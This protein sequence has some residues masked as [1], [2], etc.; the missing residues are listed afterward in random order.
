MKAHYL[1]QLICLVGG[2]DKSGKLLTAADDDRA[3]D[4]ID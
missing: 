3:A 4:Q 2:F 1:L